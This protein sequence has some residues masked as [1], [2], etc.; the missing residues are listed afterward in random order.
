MANVTGTYKESNVA[1]IAAAITL[2]DAHLDVEEARLTA[3][4]GAST[5]ITGRLTLSVG[6][7][8]AGNERY[9]HKIKTTLNCSSVADAKTLTAA[10][11]VFATAV[12]AESDYTDV[13]AVDILMYTVFSD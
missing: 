12:E 11:S 10:L 7:E 5:L 9:N 3:I 13:V 2:I 4:S 8:N 6:A 1:S